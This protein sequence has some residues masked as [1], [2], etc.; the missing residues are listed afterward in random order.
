VDTVSDAGSI[1]AASTI[2]QRDTNKVIDFPAVKQDGQLQLAARGEISKK[3]SNE[4]MQ[5]IDEMFAEDE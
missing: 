3:S 5:A 2:E 1:P 4:L